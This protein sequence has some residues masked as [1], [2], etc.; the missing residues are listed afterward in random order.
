MKKVVKMDNI[1]RERAH[2]IGCRLNG[3]KVLQDIPKIII[4]VDFDD[5]VSRIQVQKPAAFAPVVLRWREGEEVHVLV[6]M[7]ERRV[8]VPRRQLRS[9]HGEFWMKVGYH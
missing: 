7:L 8:D 3:R 4:V 5:M 9:T 1:R 2:E 6:C